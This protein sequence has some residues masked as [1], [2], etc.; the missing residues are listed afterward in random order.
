MALVQDVLSLDDF[1]VCMIN[2]LTVC[3]QDGSTEFFR[4][5]LGLL[6]FVA[7]NDH[8]VFMISE[9]VA[10]PSFFVAS[11]LGSSNHTDIGLLWYEGRSVGTAA[12]PWHGVSM[13]RQRTGARKRT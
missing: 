11:R 8:L 3:F 12:A 10:K 1:Q 13:R 2:G 4:V 6:R 5:N 7:A 9:L